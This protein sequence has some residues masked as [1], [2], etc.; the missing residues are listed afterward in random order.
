MAKKTSWTVAELYDYD[1][2]KDPD[3]YCKKGKRGNGQ[4]SRRRLIKKYG[5]K[6]QLCGYPGFIEL[7][8]ILPVQFGGGPEDSNLILLC[9]KCHA[10][11]HGYLKKKWIDSNRKYWIPDEDK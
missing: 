2:D 3:G 5:H 6:C 10:D 1:F 11:A 9:E 8:H 4:C 7:H